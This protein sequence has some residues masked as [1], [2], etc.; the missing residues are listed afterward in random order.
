MYGRGKGLVGSEAKKKEI[1]KKRKL[2][3]VWSTDE[4]KKRE[5]KRKQEQRKEIR[6]EKRREEMRKRE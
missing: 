2:S 6:N 4:V 1:V 3:I 5:G